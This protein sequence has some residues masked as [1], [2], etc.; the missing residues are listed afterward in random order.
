MYEQSSPRPNAGMK[1]VSVGGEVGGE[2]GGG[3]GSN[4]RFRDQGPDSGK[5]SIKPFHEQPKQIKLY[6][7]IISITSNLN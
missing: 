2:G 5:V 7:H 6:E 3:G 1:R 4:T